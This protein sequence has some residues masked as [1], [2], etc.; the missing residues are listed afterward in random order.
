VRLFK[1][2]GFARFARSEKISDASLR[3]AVSR[4]ERGLIDADLG[5]SIIKQRVARAAQGRSGG[6][7]ALI[8]FRPAHRAVFIVGFAKSACANI[9]GSELETAKKVGAL[10]LDATPI[11][12]DLAID[13][14]KLVEVPHEN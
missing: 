10:W 6:Y 14:G 12:I 7:R 3:E 5:G 1:I 11:E 8:A 4:V 13:E 2:K 9:S